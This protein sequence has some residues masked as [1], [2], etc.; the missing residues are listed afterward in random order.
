MEL[1]EALRAIGSRPEPFSTYTADV[2]WTDPHI[3]EQMLGFHLDGTVDISSR[4]T[5]FIEASVAWMSEAFSLGPGVSVLDLGCG[6]GLY[7][8]RWARCGADVTSIDFS[9]RSIAYAREDAA[10]KGLAVNYVH[11]DHL[12]YQPT[13]T[14]DLITMIMYLDGTSLAGEVER[15]GLE[16]DAVLGDVAG[17]AFDPMA[18][19]FALTA[20]KKTTGQP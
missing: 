6:P 16:V 17:R 10:R 8:N 11:A 15:A 4:R 9:A 2:L 1:Y 12:S 20:R 19:E 13:R 5:S 7:T 18:S 14:F 3:S